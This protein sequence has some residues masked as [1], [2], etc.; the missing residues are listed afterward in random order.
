VA[1]F[2]KKAIQ[3][4]EVTF[5]SSGFWEDQS[6]AT[7][8]EGPPTPE[9]DAAWKHLVR[10]GM[11]SLTK[12]ENNQLGIETSIVPGRKDEYLVTLEVFHQL[13]CLVYRLRLS[14]RKEIHILT[15]QQN[16][17][18]KRSYGIVP[19]EAADACVD[20]LRQVLMCHGD[21]TPITLTYNRTMDFVSLNFRIKHTCRNFESIWQF[22]AKG[23]RSGISIEG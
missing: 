22:V 17:L 1:A 10:V 8:Y 23:N 3:Y 20:Y 4:E 7:P 18:R 19:S 15:T 12:E 2:A 14:L 21:L 13:H 11:Y 5:D 6:R 9:V 16:Y